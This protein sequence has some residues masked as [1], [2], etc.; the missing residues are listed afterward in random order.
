MGRRGRDGDRLNV[1]FE[2]GRGGGVATGSKMSGPDE[3]DGT[4]KAYTEVGEDGMD[5]GER[6]MRSEFLLGDP[7]EA[8][9]EVVVKVREELGESEEIL[10]GE[11]GRLLA[12]G[13][14]HRWRWWWFE[15][16]VGRTRAGGDLR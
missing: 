8:D 5:P 1:S 3:R 13:V 15:D 9:E 7:R 10:T 6:V 16:E 11:G 4:K 2:D 12:G 14:C